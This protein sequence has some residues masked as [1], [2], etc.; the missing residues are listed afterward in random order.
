MTLLAIGGP[1][2]LPVNM[3]PITHPIPSR[4]QNFASRS[5]PAAKR[6]VATPPRAPETHRGVRSDVGSARLCNN[7]DPAPAMAPSSHNSHADAAQ[8]ERIGL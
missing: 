4:Q 2:R 8:S 7:L 1:V 3:I 6:S 5:R